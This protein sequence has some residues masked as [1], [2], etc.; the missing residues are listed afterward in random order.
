MS[1]PARWTIFDTPILSTV[2]RWVSRAVLR[3]RGWRMVVDLPEEHRFVAVFAPHTSYWDTPLMLM[4]AFANRVRGHWLGT[5]N[6]FRRPFGWL[7]RWLGGIP[8]D[9]TKT[10]GIVAAAIQQFREHPA[11]V[12]G[13][14]PEGTRFRAERWKTG[15]YHIAAGAGVPIVLTFIDASTRTIGAGGWFVPSGDF[16][17]DAGRIRRF[18][19]GKVGIRAERTTE[20][21]I[22]PNGD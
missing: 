8:V 20:P 2:I 15:F 3:L 9:R 1:R 21:V 22:A 14:A 13:L 7:F 19:A 11:L 12:L 10:N 17:A 5:H 16:D 6:L 4:A 18:Y